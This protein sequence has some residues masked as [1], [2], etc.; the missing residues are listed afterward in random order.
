MKTATNR[1]SRGHRPAGAV[2]YRDGIPDVD[3]FARLLDQTGW[4]AGD[5][6]SC[7]ELSR[8]LTASWFATGAY[9]GG[10]LVAVGRVLS[11]GCLHALIVD[12]ITD[13]EWQH[14]GLATTIMTRLLAARDGAHIRDVQ[15]FCARGKRPFYE[16]LGFFARPNDAP[17]MDLGR[18]GR[19]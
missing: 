7:D 17:G 19:Q 18:G 5:P 2:E 3:E 1:S 11:D 13:E 9:A 8:T 12:V 16:R 14:R 15:L 4:F 10:R 6:P